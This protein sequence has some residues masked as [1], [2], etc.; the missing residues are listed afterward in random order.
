[1]QGLNLRNDTGRSPDRRERVPVLVPGAGI[2]PARPCGQRILS[3]VRLPVSP[4][5]QAIDSVP[6]RAVEWNHHACRD[7][8]PD[9]K[10]PRIRRA[11]RTGAGKGARTLDLNL[12]K[13]AL[14]QLSYSRMK[15]IVPCPRP[16]WCAGWRPGSESN[17]RTRICN[18][19][20][21]HSATR[22]VTP[23][24]TSSC[25]QNETPRVAR[26]FAF[27]TW[28]GKRGSNPRPQP[29]QGCALPTEL[30][31]LGRRNS[32]RRHRG[33]NTCSSPQHA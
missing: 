9:T 5:G 13:V 15:P 32:T 27:E 30:F 12:G 16:E 4:S 23:C 8:R 26:G 33:V 19:L 6:Q 11:F 28:S 3:P 31:P 2:E 14:Y 20:H 22:P 25:R 21:N 10:K 29:W 18:P 1:M 17:R 24:R 7:A